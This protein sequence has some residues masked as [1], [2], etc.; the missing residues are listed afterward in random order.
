MNSTLKFFK[1]S[2]TP[3]V[4]AQQNN[5]VA[6]LPPPPAHNGVVPYQ[7]PGTAS[8]DGLFRPAPIYA[9]PQPSLQQ[10]QSPP[11]PPPNPYPTPPASSTYSAPQR[12]MSPPI[13]QYPRQQV[14]GGFA[15]PPGRAQG[16]AYG[17]RSAMSGEA[18]PAENEGKLS[19][20]I[21]FG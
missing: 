21:D 9:S 19:V 4:P 8:P 16:N 14:M 18:A 2:K 6:P 15:S 1:R 13:A 17:G 20:G 7:Q 5:D 12:A 3:A 10:Q 11:P